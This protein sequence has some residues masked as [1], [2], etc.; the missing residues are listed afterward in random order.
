[1]IDGPG[2]PGT[3]RC[4][5]GPTGVLPTSSWALICRSDPGGYGRRDTQ[6]ILLL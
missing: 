6:R 3:V 5:S 2:P 1:M 4:T